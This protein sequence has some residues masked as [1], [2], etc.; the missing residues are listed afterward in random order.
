MSAG[1][2]L[3]LAS[4]SPRRREL[5]QSLGL[6]F[7]V[8]P[9]DIDETPRVGETADTLVRRLA[10]EK[11]AHEIHRGEAVLAAD[12]VVVLGDDILGKPEDPANAR[13][14]LTALQGRT[15]VVH[16]GIALA[17]GPDEAQCSGEV[18]TTR[19]RL[20][21]MTDAEIDW[22]AGTGE[23]DDKAG[24]Y[25]IQGQGALFVE[26]IDGNYTNVVGL[27]LPNVY[28]LFRRAGLDLR[29]AR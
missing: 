24:S 11:A 21:A 12:T 14:M 28:Q 17:L 27:P 15:H 2:Q 23:P 13:R 4:G 1:F 22:Y 6:D 25:A 8:R 9:S 18:V 7:V 10:K 20:A 29:R 3:V 26:S 5:L 16:T 19:V